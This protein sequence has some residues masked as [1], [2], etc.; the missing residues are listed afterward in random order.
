MHLS[1]CIFLHV[2]FSL[3]LSP[4]VFLLLCYLVLLHLFGRTAHLSSFSSDPRPQVSEGIHEGFLGSESTSTKTKA[5]KV[6]EQILNTI[7]SIC[8]VC[9]FNTVQVVYIYIYIY[10]RLFNYIWCKSVCICILK[11]RDQDWGFCL[12]QVFRIIRS[13]PVIVLSSYHATNLRRATRQAY[14]VLPV[15]GLNLSI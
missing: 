6:N 10:S 5:A 14:A 2:S 3:C 13:I 11:P 4:Y 9:I 7:N 12:L 15:Q 1:P 8:V